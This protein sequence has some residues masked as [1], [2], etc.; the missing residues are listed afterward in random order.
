MKVWENV[1][2]GTKISESV[3]G[4]VEVWVNDSMEK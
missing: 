4:R 2:M 1:R 3:N